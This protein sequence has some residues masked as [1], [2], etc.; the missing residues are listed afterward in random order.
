[1]WETREILIWGTTYPNLSDSYTE[2][3]CTGGCFRDGSPVRIYLIPKRYLPRSQSF[4]HYTRIEAP[5][6][7]NP[8]DPRPESYK[9]KWQEID[10]GENVST[11]GG[12]KLR[13]DVLFKD[14]SWH[15]NRVEELKKE[16][17]KDGTSLG[18]VKVGAV[19][20]VYI[21][22]R[23]DEEKKQ[24]DRKLEAIKSQYELFDHKVKNLEF[25]KHR[26]AVEWK[27]QDREN[28]SGHN[29]QILDWGLAELARK[30]GIKT[31]RKKIEELTDLDTYDL[32]FFMGNFRHHPSAFGIVGAWYPKIEHIEEASLPLFPNQ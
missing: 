16:Q 5:V 31:A 24:H 17:Q 25:Q 8:Q 32:R 11:K 19:D 29:M 10:V 3:V 20:N 26:I 23:S 13:K 27:C 12:W 30:R 9:I 21:K 4:S 1:M 14:Q 6:R 2:T 15:Y 7:K 18:M 28:C 22:S